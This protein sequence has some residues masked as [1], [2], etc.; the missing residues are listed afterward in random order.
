[1]ICRHR[2]KA[3]LY[4]EEEGNGE[5]ECS[6]TDTCAVAQ[7]IQD[8]WRGYPSGGADA[9]SMAQILR[10][11]FGPYVNSRGSRQAGVADF[12]AR[13]PSTPLFSRGSEASHFF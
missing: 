12:F 8:R 10:Q 6:I 4:M 11:P 1:M 3:L 2:L 13:S 5:S 9:G 7:Q